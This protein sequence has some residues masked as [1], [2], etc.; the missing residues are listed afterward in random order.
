M[1]VSIAIFTYNHEEFI[2]K[3][4]DEVLRQR[5]DF[6][7][8]IVIGEDCS[9]DNTRS[10]LL[11]YQRKY[12]GK[13]VLLL[14]ETN[15]GANRNIDQALKRCKGEYLAL[16]DGDDY[17]TSRDKLQ[18][19]VEFLD[20]HPDC[21]VCFHDALI[22]YKD[23]SKEPAHY[24]PGQKEFS[25]VE[26]L[27]LDNFIPTSSVMFRR[28]LFSGIPEWIGRLKMGDWPSHILN[29]QS[30]TIG[31]I[32]ETMGVYLVHHGGVW[33]TKDC[34]EH[35]HATIELFEALEKHLD[36]KYTRIIRTILR[37]RCF[38]ASELFESSGDVAT[39]RTYAVKSIAKHFLLLCEPLGFESRI[40]EHSD[41]ILP[42]Y[43]K[44]LNGPKI[45]KSLLRLYVVPVVK[46]Y[47]PTL[48]KVL[49]GCCCRALAILGARD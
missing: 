32:D 6:D 38:A 36:S 10:I 33:S 23:R 14:N 15:L 43:M 19:Q 26:D 31:Y 17:W 5:T 29:A 27:L 37:W 12:P 21:S 4:L 46:P 39:A 1:K 9:T 34:Q 20:K 2:A 41:N 16:L 22:V 28:S 48:Y 35:T 8:E 47:V 45:F 18:K 11:E 7:Y 13:I 3:A 42:D 49:R 40:D 30:G 44:S 25:T 24:R